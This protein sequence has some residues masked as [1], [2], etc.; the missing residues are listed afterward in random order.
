M[1]RMFIETH[2]AVLAELFDLVLEPDSV[3]TEYASATEFH[4]RYGFRSKPSRIRFRII[5]PTIR[6]ASLEGTPDVEMDADSFAAL[7]LPIHRVFVTENEINFLAFPNVPGAIVLFGAG[8]SIPLLRHAGWIASLR[9]YYWGDIDTHGF[10]ILD[11][12]RGHFGHVESMLMDRETMLRYRSSWS[13]EAAQVKRALYAL[14]PDETRLFKDLQDGAFGDGARL[15]Q[16][17]IAY[18]HLASVLQNL[19][20]GEVLAGGSHS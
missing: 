2:R 10:A 11:G 19:L 8:Y 6:W 4:S 14:T 20:A 17:K 13:L 15:E 16:E 1:C 5:D 18:P 3:R 9:L 7:R 12:L